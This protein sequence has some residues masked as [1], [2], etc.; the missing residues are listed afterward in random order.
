M[1]QAKDEF[2]R[3]VCLSVCLSVHLGKKKMMKGKDADRCLV[4]K[5]VPY[6]CMSLPSYKK[7]QMMTFRPVVPGLSR[8]LAAYVSLNR[9]PPSLRLHAFP[10]H[11][12]VTLRTSVR[13]NDPIEVVQRLDCVHLFGVSR[14][15]SPT[16]YNLVCPSR[17]Q[18]FKPSSSP[19]PSL[20]ST[21]FKNGPP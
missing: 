17:R 12:G 18:I 2:D 14:G 1:A 9:M 13:G 20:R 11:T 6:F 21:N 16:F 8:L 4:P 5:L 10:H 7:A 3:K 15:T 19:P